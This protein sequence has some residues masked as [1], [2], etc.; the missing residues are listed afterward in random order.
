[1]SLLNNI[2]NESPTK[3]RS[4][5]KIVD[6]GFDLFSEEGI[7]AVSLSSIAEKSGITIRNLYRY[8]PCKE[9]LITDVAYHYISIFNNVNKIV[10]NNDLSG[11]EQLKDLL[12]KQVGNKLLGEDNNKVL[13]FI[14][15]FDIYI[16]KSNIEH[17]AIKNYINVY[18]PLLKENI[19]GSTKQAL[20]NGVED[21]TLNLEMKEVDHYLGYIFHSTMSIVSRIALKRYEKDIQNFD[22]VQKHINLILHRLKK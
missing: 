9:S 13:A 5:L 19:L 12:E 16:T 15:Y 20:I 22:F 3:A 4:R 8:Y 21:N 10:L 18:A 6:N 11:Y 1:M 17:K 14:A 2:Y 7:D